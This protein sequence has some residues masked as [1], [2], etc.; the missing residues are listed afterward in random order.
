MNN[1][2][3]LQHVNKNN[4]F[5]PLMFN[6]L[7]L[8]LLAGC[9]FAPEY[10]Q[11]K[12]DLPANWHE[13]DKNQEAIAKNWW[14]KF[15]DPT[16]NKVIEKTLQNNYDLLIATEQLAK[17]EA[18]IG[19]TRADLFPTIGANAS[20]GRSMSSSQPYQDTSPL[21]TPKRTNS[22]YIMNFQAAWELD[23]WGKYRN[24][25]NAAREQMLMASYS[26]EALKLMLI[27]ESARA[28]FTLLSLDGQLAISQRTLKTRE[29]SL[30][31]YTAQYNEGLI[32]E[33]DYL[34]ASTEVDTVKMSI[35]ELIYQVDN[36]ETAL[37]VLMGESPRILFDESFKRGYSLNDLKPFITLPAGI[38]SDLLTRRP[39][40]MAA[41]AN[42]KAANFNVG[43]AKANWF[44]SISL[45]GLLGLES[46]ELADLFTGPANTWTYG[47][48][49]TTPIFQAG[50][51]S[52]SVK[53]AEATMREAALNYQKA[54][55]S[56]FK[57]VRISLS[58]QKS[59]GN[60]VMALEDIVN[61]LD[62][63]VNLAQIR[64]D[65]GY[66]SYLEVLDAQRSL[67][68][69]EIQL[70][71]AKASQLITI[72]NIYQ[73]LGGGWQDIAQ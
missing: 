63:A 17:A 43:V 70:E 66:A 3:S 10:V 54:V 27:T 67:F 39:D 25:N 71:N 23:F 68:E 29:E 36:A 8:F 33:L 4:F 72:L 1:V 38:P 56:A 59:I 13:T 60:V 65:N 9:S 55:Q 50:K 11:P 37:Q 61:S 28:Y 48:S 69:A 16:L 12:M 2:V 32:N 19:V 57:D 62:K 51:I 21:L 5:F 31:I 30:R 6:V 47:V 42:L 49:L 73:A 52:S 14:E 46:L 64:Y 24:A 44:P 45:T 22:T 15:N 53:V 41:E 7:M 35:A 58:V 18:Y 20:A 40:I 34:R 26:K